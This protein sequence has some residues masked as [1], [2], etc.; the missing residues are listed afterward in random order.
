MFN[1][2]DFS[3][4]PANYTFCYISECPQKDQCLRYLTASHQQVKK[5]QILVVNPSLYTGE[6][7]RFF[8]DSTPI[9]VAYGMKDSFLD[10][11]AVHSTE[12]HKALYDEFG[13]SNFF[14]L[15]DGSHPISPETQQIIR[16]IF[17]KYGYEVTFDRMEEELRWV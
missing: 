4:M 14:R 6:G 12:I 11:R 3:K 7:C 15:R 8:K 10:V 17:S 1:S 13:R 5:S 16:K 2:V 9:M